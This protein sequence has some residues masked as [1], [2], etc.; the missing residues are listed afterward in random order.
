MRE[1]LFDYNKK[2]FFDEHSYSYRGNH[3]GPENCTKPD[4]VVGKDGFVSF[5][6]AEVD[7]VRYYVEKRLLGGTP[8]SKDGKNQFKD[9]VVS[10]VES[11]IMTDSNGWQADEFVRTY[12]DLKVYGMIVWDVINAQDP[13]GNNPSSQRLMILNY[14]GTGYPLK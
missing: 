7:R 9:D 13:S 5:P 1:R 14:V 12:G 8:L 11:L 3:S 6:T 10:M 4:Q 2:E